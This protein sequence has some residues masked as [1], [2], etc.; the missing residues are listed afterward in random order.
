MRKLTAG[1]IGLLAAMLAV[2][3]VMPWGL[4]VAGQLAEGPAVLGDGSVLAVEN[5]P[6]VS[7]IYTLREETPAQIY[8][9]L[10][11][12]QSDGREY[13]AVRVAADGSEAYFLRVFQGGKD[14]ELMRLEGTKAVSIYQGTFEEDVTVTGLAAKNGTVW[15]TAIGGNKAI[16]VYEYTESQGE[17][18]KLV[19]PA[20]W[21]WDVVSAEFDGERIRATTAQGD[22]YYVTPSGERTY[23]EAAAET[24]APVISAAGAGWLLCKR[25][26]FLAVGALWLVI[27]ASVV[28]VYLVIRKTERLAT[29]MTAMGLEVLFLALLA[30]NVWVFFLVLGL[31]GIPAAFRAAAGTAAVGAV[32]WLAGWLL[33]LGLSRRMTKPVVLLA[34]QM[35]QMAEGNFQAR[36]VLAGRDELH[37]MDQAVQLLCMSLS[38]RNYEVDSMIRAYERFVPEKLTQLLERAN[39]AEVSLGDSRR[40]LGDVGLFSVGNRDEV[41][42]VLDD[43]AFVDF[44]NHSFGIFQTCIQDNRGCM[45]SNGL[46]LSAMETLFPSAPEDGVRAGLD[47]LGR[48]QK[49]SGEG[50][51][52]PRPMLLL[53][54]APILY[55]IAGQ[56]SRLYP[57]LSSSELEFLGGF[58]QR[59][60]EAGACMVATEAY[61]EQLKGRGFTGRYIGFVSN[62]EK[63]AYKLY[64]ILDAYPELERKLRVGYDHRMQEAINL[65]YHDDFYLARNLFSM[66]LRA[67]PEDGIVRWYLFACEHFFHQEGEF[68]VDYSLFG[69]REL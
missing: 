60:Y 7:R 5:R 66:L 25:S 24:P 10:R 40:L 56:E 57:Y 27:A 42:A 48:T 19:H 32:V 64:E 62:G 1:L 4:P 33:L 51:P 2:A 29:R 65:F 43:D 21:L 69:I 58:S 68:E 30:S 9:E 11:I 63:E 50:I 34:E 44:I 54:R 67:C 6:L 20:W 47:F 39:V 53:H 46:R 13:T 16:F 59:L 17:K 38:I 3:A 52:A 8:E 35:D 36:D 22:H 23:D 18:L 61:W 26:V 37:R 31:A 49:K 28:A 41:R 55:G 15:I 45:I 14:W 12:R